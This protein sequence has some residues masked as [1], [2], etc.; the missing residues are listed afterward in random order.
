MVTN[1]SLMPCDGCGQPASAEHIARRLRRLEWTTRYRPV[2]IGTLLLGA[3]P[4]EE[5]SE[6]LYGGSDPF[7][8]EAARVLKA[9]GVNYADKTSE[10]VLADFQR[11]GFLLTHVLECPLEAVGN[12]EAPIVDQL[13]EKRIAAVLS[14]I[15]RS[16]KPK[17]LV[18]LSDALG[19]LTNLFAKQ[20]LGCSLV[21]DHG[22]PFL[23]EEQGADPTGGWLR[24]ALAAIYPATR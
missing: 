7:R 11:R 16:L 17:Q 6:F 12:G 19:P 4:P 2:H 23:L 21:L 9:V 1:I 3:F 20:D 14:R 18:L 8:G 22:K 10:A 24:E 13:L 5:D 15:R